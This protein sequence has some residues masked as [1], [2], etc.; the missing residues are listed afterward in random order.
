MAPAVQEPRP[1]PCSPPARSEAERRPPG[2]LVADDDPAV[3]QVL[4][5]FLRQAG[6]A[7]WCAE[8]GLDAVRTYFGYQ[9]CIDLV[10]LDIDM[11]LLDGCH[12][13]RVLRRVNPLVRFCFMSG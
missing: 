9:Q 10:L 8:N 4:A 11:P 5:W 3:R 7:V 2:I 1:A 6:C 12:A 13:A